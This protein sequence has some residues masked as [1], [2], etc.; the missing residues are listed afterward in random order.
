MSLHLVSAEQLGG[1]WT[2]TICELDGS[3]GT[4]EDRSRSL[5]SSGHMD[6]CPGYSQLPWK[7]ATTYSANECEQREAASW[8]RSEEPTR[9]C[10]EKE[11]WFIQPAPPGR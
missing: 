1:D 6:C 5:P 8:L 9:L 7:P 3:K 4:V 2:R 10:Q 11:R